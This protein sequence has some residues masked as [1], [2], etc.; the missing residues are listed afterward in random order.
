MP[1]NQCVFGIILGIHD[2]KELGYKMG[3]QIAENKVLFSHRGK[4]RRNKVRN[5]EKAKSI[6]NRI[7]DYPGVVLQR[8]SIQLY[9][10]S[11]VTEEEDFNESSADY[12]NDSDGQSDEEESDSEGEEVPKTDSL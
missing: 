3:L 5:I 8:P 10:R 6:M 2:M 4:N 1:H 11:S 12:Y 7:D 9:Q